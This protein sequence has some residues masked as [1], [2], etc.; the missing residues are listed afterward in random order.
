MKVVIKY[1]DPD[2]FNIEEVVAQAKKLHGKGTEIEV[3][4][5]SNL[6]HDMLYFALQQMTT[7]KQLS[8]LYDEGAQYHQKLNLLRAE[9]L[10]KVTELLDEVIM[11]TEARTEG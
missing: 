2:S 5:D 10:Y 4:P 3:Y 11:D 6:P 1:Q 9:I 8:L 7:Q